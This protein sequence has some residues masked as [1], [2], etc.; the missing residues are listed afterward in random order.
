M[1]EIQRQ[2]SLWSV[3]GHKLN[4]YL[5]FRVARVGGMAQGMGKLG[6]EAKSQKSTRYWTLPFVGIAMISI[7]GLSRLFDRIFTEPDETLSFLVI[8]RRKR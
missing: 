2:G 1:T 5:A 7:T 8:A 6:H 4:S 3:I